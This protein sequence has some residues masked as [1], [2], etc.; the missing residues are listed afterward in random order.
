MKSLAMVGSDGNVFWPPIVRMRS[1]C[2]MDIT[3][4]PFDDQICTLKLGSWAYDG[5]QVDVT[6]R[7]LDVDLSNYVDNGEWTLIDTKAVRNVK[8]YTCCPEPF[9]DVTF[10]LH[11]RR[12]VLYYAFNVII[13]CVLLS[14]LT[15]TGFLLPPESGEKVTLGL[16]VLLAFSVFMLLIAENMPP[17][18]E[19]I[20]LIG[21]NYK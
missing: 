13:P 20:P 10:Y 12:R 19:Y 16:T 6:N 9:P 3:Y 14:M 21:K 17:T 1:A 2:K 4:F 15:L 8:I 11:L 18:S 5:F 7:T